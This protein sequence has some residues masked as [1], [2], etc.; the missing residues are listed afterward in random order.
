M[1]KVFF[2]SLG[3]TLVF[4]FLFSLIWGVKGKDFWIVL[5]MN[6][7]TNPLVVW[8]HYSNLESSVW[9]HT[10]LPEVVAAGAEMLIL[11]RFSK[12]IPCPL[13]FGFLVNMFSYC[14]GG[15]ILYI[16]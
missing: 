12:H 7:L 11:R 10:F 8:W 15:V 1:G 9:I 3:L 14:L 4:E 13:L 6:C 5:L 2:L 16:F